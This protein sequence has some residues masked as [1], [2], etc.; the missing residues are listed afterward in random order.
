[1]QDFSEQFNDVL[2][3]NS[4]VSAYRLFLD[5]KNF[6]KTNIS[7]QDPALYNMKHVTGYLAI[8]RLQEDDVLDLI[9]N[10][11]NVVFEI[12]N[13][14]ILARM[15]DLLTNYENLDDRDELK[16]KI[17]TALRESN[18]KITTPS[19]NIGNIQEDPTISNWLK[20]FR[21]QFTEGG[22][23]DALNITKFIN[24]DKN[25]F[26]LPDKEKNKI[27]ILLNFYRKLSISSFDP[28]GME[29]DFII[30]DESG[31]LYYFN[32]GEFTKLGIKK[33]IETEI[34]ND[35]TDDISN[36]I[37]I[38]RSVSAV[39]KVFVQPTPVKIPEPVVKKQNPAEALLVEYKS[40]EKSISNTKNDLLLFEKYK[41]NL[42]EFYGEFDEMIRSKD[43]QK[44]I[45][46]VVFIAKNKLINIF[47]KNNKNLFIEFKKSLL[48][49]FD[50]DIVTS[51]SN[52]LDSIE[53]V[54]L[55]LQFLFTRFALTPRETGLYGMYIANIFKKSGQEKYFPIVYGDINLGQ[56][57]FRDVVEIAGKLKLK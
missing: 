29:N 14:D 36:N 11:F 32:K 51:I 43:K 46:A 52:N 39:N 48:L 18:L 40:F 55:Y 4:I 56:F 54:S 9:S 16:A 26:A 31:E 1:M 33:D 10:H 3:D 20:Y 37:D 2:N 35:N 7:Q 25:F 30:E 5:I 22:F 45:S 23:I 34:I 38:N 12:D 24:S 49:K 47:I 57:L 13:Y 27:E 41:N 53:T 42:D 17:K 6:L 8:S 28:M 19:L 44:L 15:N 21:G 50:E